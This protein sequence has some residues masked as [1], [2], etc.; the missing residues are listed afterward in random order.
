MKAYFYTPEECG[1]AEFPQGLMRLTG[2]DI[3]MSPEEADVFVVPC[4]IN[5]I[6]AIGIKNLPY[7]K[8]NESRH[9]ALNIAD[10]FKYVTEVPGMWFRCD[11]TRSVVEREP[12]TIPWP[13]PVDDLS[14]YFN[15]PFERDAVFVGW[16]S[17]DINDV[18]CESII[19]E[20][21]LDSLV[22]RKNK[23][24]GW[25]PES[26]EKQDSHTFFVD[27]LAGSR[28]SLCVRSI[29]AGVCRYR[30]YESISMGRIVAHI[31]DGHTYPLADR[32]DY[33]AF[34]IDIPECEAEHTGEIIADFLSSHDD[35]DLRERGAYARDM[36]QRWLHRDRWD[37]LFGE[38]V[39][40]KLVPVGCIVREESY[41]W[42][43]EE[44]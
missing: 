31:C 2:F 4:G 23:F 8:G 11:S 37:E 41:L 38:V 13:W 9:A 18:A 35:N 5:Y 24:Y 33:S 40:E 14:E 15:R 10:W 36:F 19:A 39:T 17:T 43:K 20:K 21:R 42:A 12:S 1:M 26:Q 25:I 7:L 32:I 30:F 3:T 22:A 34:V 29:E 6:G 16:N 28:V 44:S 27:T